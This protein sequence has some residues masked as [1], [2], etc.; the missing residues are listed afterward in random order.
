MDKIKRIIINSLEKYENNDKNKSNNKYLNFSKEIDNNFVLDVCLNNNSIDY[1]KIFYY[2][3]N[4]N[5]SSDEY[6]TLISKDKAIFEY[7]KIKLCL[8]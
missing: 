8:I 4:D 6:D 2:Q 5:Y 3:N 7:E 1:T